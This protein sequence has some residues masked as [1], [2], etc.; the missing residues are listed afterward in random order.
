MRH[1]D[2]KKPDPDQS[3][4]LSLRSPGI[5][6]A[7]LRID[8]MALKKDKKFVL[9]IRIETFLKMLYLDPYRM[10]T[11]PKPCGNELSAS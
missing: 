5:F 10:I 3:P 2:P 9:W 7:R 11:D 8:S 1:S 4:Y 6:S